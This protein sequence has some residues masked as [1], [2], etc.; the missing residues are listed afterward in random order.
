MVLQD[1]CYKFIATTSLWIMNAQIAFN[2]ASVPNSQSHTLRHIK[3]KKYNVIQAS[4]STSVCRPS[5]FSYSFPFSAAAY[6][7]CSLQLQYKMEREG[8]PEER[9]AYSF[10][11]YIGQALNKLPVTNTVNTVTL[12]L[13]YSP[14]N[15]CYE[16]HKCIFLRCRYIRNVDPLSQK[17]CYK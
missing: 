10:T 13:P 4:L 16:T 17:H 15:L 12:Q 7:R 1:S 9:G 14:D 6:H 2:S 5:P 11:G 3:T 8:T